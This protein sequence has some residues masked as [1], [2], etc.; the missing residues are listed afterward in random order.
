MF[1]WSSPK[2]H[3]LL[4]FWYKLSFGSVLFVPDFNPIDPNH[5]ELPSD[6][7]L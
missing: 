4:V 2:D 7:M 5:N 1:D 3:C 6:K